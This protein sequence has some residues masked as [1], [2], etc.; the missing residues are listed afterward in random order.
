[1]RPMASSK[2][3]SSLLRSPSALFLPPVMKD[4]MAFS[5]VVRGSAIMGLLKVGRYHEGEVDLEQFSDPDRQRKK[6]L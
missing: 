3:C 6:N 1:M 4:V 2:S 5:V